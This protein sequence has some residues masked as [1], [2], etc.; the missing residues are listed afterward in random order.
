MIFV[1]EKIIPTEKQINQLYSLLKNRKHSISHEKL[2]SSKIHKK[3]VLENPYVELYLIYK[4]NH[5]LG[6]IYIQS[7]NSIGMDLKEPAKSD[8]IE[9][10]SF[11][12]DNHKPLFPIKSVRRGEF[13]INISP[14]NLNMIK[15]LN[16]LNKIEIQRSFLV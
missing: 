12:K 6:S 2:P 8:V 7:D 10:I 9:A 11:I 5:I 3:F 1:Y 15:I 4:K 14:N 13:Y 16:E